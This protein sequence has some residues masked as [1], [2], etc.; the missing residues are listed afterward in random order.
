[1]SKPSIQFFTCHLELMQMGLQL[2]DLRTDRTSGILVIQHNR[3][4]EITKPWLLRNTQRSIK[5]IA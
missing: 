4:V 3:R 5:V 1:M 2:P